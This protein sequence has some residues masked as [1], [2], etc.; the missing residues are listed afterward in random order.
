MLRRGWGF[1]DGGTGIGVPF[2]R[3][4]SA[5]TSFQTFQTIK[6]VFFSVDFQLISAFG[7]QNA[8]PAFRGAESGLFFGGLFRSCPRSSAT[9]TYGEAPLA[10]GGRNFTQTISC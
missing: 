6:I 8:R 2:H 1:W 7:A 3:P 9:A 10:T 5:K 4:F